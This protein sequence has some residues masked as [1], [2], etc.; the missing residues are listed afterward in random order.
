MGS[1]KSSFSVGQRFGRWVVIDPEVG[2]SP[3]NA[4]LAKCICDCGNEGLINSSRL[5]TGKTLSCGCRAGEVTRSIKT[6]HGMRGTPIY[7]IWQHMK[8]R[9]FNSNNSRY[10]NYGARGI[11]VCERWLSFENFLADMGDRPDPSLSIDRIDNN[12]N[13][14][15]GNC[16]WAT[17]T[18]QARNRRT[19]TKIVLFG[20]EVVLCDVCEK[21][22][23]QLETLRY[24]L[25]RGMTPEDAVTT[26]V[27]TPKRKKN[28][29]QS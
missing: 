17:D 22:G 15:P 21:Y 14:E 24:R 26:P 16:R 29:T 2:R 12:G 9:C 1:R 20:E 28:E 25:R 23:I 3:A 18:E 6:K 5:R 27:I 19:S 4:K 11:T 13:Y 10:K 7:Q 8:A